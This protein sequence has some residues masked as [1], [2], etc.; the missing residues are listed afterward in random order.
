MNLK[1]NKTNYSF[2]AKIFHWGYV[3]FFAYGVS[4]QVDN[5]SQ[6]EDS[7][8]FRFEIIGK[9]IGPFFRSNSKIHKNLEISNIGN[10][11]HEREVVIN[12]MWGNYGKIFAE[13]P[14]YVS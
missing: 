13:Y 9:K 12:N 1:I 14:F 4:K 6:L 11:H 5:L 8:F 2:I 7:F 10:S 3:I